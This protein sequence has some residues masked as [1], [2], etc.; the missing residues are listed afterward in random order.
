M[1]ARESFLS[2]LFHSFPAGRTGVGLL[3]L[4]AALGAIVLYQA[5]I[6]LSVGSNATLESW[7]GVFAGSA[8]LLIL[9]L[10]TPCAAAV[11]GVLVIVAHFFFSPAS[12]SLSASALCTALTAAMAAAIVIL[13]PGAL[14]VD[15]R[16][17]GLREIIIPTAHAK[18]SP[19][20]RSER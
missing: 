10:L 18:R 6:D 8:I 2:I 12:C 4:R 9:G 20:Q 13:G 16:L 17:F 1:Y 14:S 3:L 7:I 19:D 5:G 11:L 15:A